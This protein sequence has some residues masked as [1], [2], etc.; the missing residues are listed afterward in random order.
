[1][2]RAS[3]FV[4]ISKEFREKLAGEGDWNNPLGEA[5]FFKSPP[6]R[7]K[8]PLILRRKRHLYGDGIFLE[9]NNTEEKKK[10]IYIKK[11]R[12]SVEIYSNPRI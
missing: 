9:D 7:K 10:H 6:G 11:K 3:F 1:L 5:R 4:Q 12:P 2:N 8:S